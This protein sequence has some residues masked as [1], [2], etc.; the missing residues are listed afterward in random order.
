MSVLD[1]TSAETVKKLLKK[2][3]SHRGHVTRNFNSIRIGLGT[4]HPD[5][6]YLSDCLEAVKSQKKVIE[7]GFVSISDIYIENDIEKELDELTLDHEKY[8]TEIDTNM[9]NFYSMIFKH[10]LKMEEAEHLK[11]IPTKSSEIKSSISALKPVLPKLTISKFDGNPLK[12]TSFWDIF[13]SS[14]HDASYFA[15]I[16]KFCYLKSYL[17][18][19]AAETIEGVPTTEKGYDVA[20]E[21]LIKRFGDQAIT[22]DAY[23]VAI[24]NLPEPENSVKSLQKFS[25]K[26][27]TY[28]RLLEE[29]GKKRDDLATLLIPNI[30]NKLPNGVKKNVVRIAKNPKSWTLDEIFLGIDEEIEFLKVSAPVPEHNSYSEADC[31]TF[32]N[33]SNRPVRPPYQ[34]Q[35]NRAQPSYRP[36]YQGQQNRANPVVDAICVFCEKKHPFY[37]CDTHRD[38]RK[39]YEIIKSKHRCFVCFSDRHISVN[40]TARQQRCK[41]CSMRHNTLL[42]FSKNNTAVNFSNVESCVNMENSTVNHASDGND[43]TSNGQSDVIPV[44]NVP[45][46]PEFGAYHLSAVNGTVLLQTAQ[47]MVTNGQSATQANFLLD[48]GSQRSFISKKMCDILGLMPIKSET[49]KLSTFGSANTEVRNL[50]VVK[51]SII[52]LDGSKIEIFPLVIDTVCT[53]I[54]FRHQ[55]NLHT[56]HPNFVNLKFS[57]IINIGEFSVDILIGLDAYFSIVIGNIVQ[58]YTSG[59]VAIKTK[60]G[61]VVC[62]KVN[63]DSDDCEPVSNNFVHILKVLTDH[64]DL[65]ARLKTFWDLE[66]ISLEHPSSKSQKA[67]FDYNSYVNSIEYKDNKYICK[68]PVKSEHQDL[69]N[70]YLYCA[71]RLRSLIRNLLTRGMLDK[72][73]D[74]IKI[75]EKNGIIEKVNCDDK[76]GY[77]IP[78]FAVFRDSAT[79]PMRIVYDCSSTVSPEYPSLN[80]ILETGPPLQN[81][82]V[83]I[84]LKFRIGRYGLSSDISRAFH[85]LGLDSAHRGLCRFLWISDDENDK[86]SEFQIY[87]FLVILFGAKCSP[88]IL[89]ATVKK[90]LIL[91]TCEIADEILKCIY[92]DNPITTTDS[93]DHAIHFFHESRSIMSKGNFKLTAWASNCEEVNKLAESNSIAD[94]NLESVKVLGLRWNTHSDNLC[95]NPINF[96]IP[97]NVVTKRIALQW[98]SKLY[99]PL[100]VMAAVLMTGKLFMQEMWKLKFSWDIPFTDDL[101]N[102]WIDVMLNL[103]KASNFK[104]KRCILTDCTDKPLKLFAFCDASK[105][106]YACSLYLSDGITCEFIFS[107]GRVAPLKTVDKPELSLPRLELMAAYMLVRVVKFIKKSLSHLNLTEYYFSDSQVVLN[108]IHYVDRNKVFEFNRV[109]DI[110]EL[111]TKDQWYYVDSDNNPSDIVTRGC[112]YDKLI[113]KDN[114]FNGPAFLLKGPEY[115]PVWER[116]PPS[117]TV[118]TVNI[119]PQI[120]ENLSI[121]NLIDIE[122]FSS[123]SKLL[124]VTAYVLRAFKIN[125]NKGP[126]TVDE[127]NNCKYLWIKA[128][129]SKYFEAEFKA[130]KKDTS[131]QLVRQLNLYIDDN[132]LKSGGRIDNSDMAET[133]KYPILLPYDSYFSKLV[134]LH[135]HKMVHHSGVNSTINRVRLEFWVPKLRQL[136]KKLLHV[137]VVCKRVTGIHYPYPKCPPLVKCRIADALPWAVTGVDLTGSVTIMSHNLV[138]VTK[139][140]I[141]LF[142]CSTT[143]N[144]HLELIPDMTVNS[145]LLAFRRFCSRRSLPNMLIS[146]NAKYFENSSV[147]LQNLF[148]SDNLV[149]EL[150]KYSVEWFFIPKR[151]PWHGAFYERMIGLTKVLLRKI[152]GKSR[153]TYIE[154]STLLTEIECTLNERPITYVSS[155]RGDP[156]PLT[157]S[158]LLYGRNLNRI[159]YP[160]VDLDE[161]YDKDFDSR[162]FLLERAKRRAYLCNHFVHRWKY[163]YLVALRERHNCKGSKLNYVKIGDVV[164]I[165]D[166]V[167][168]LDWNMGIITELKFGKDGLV[169]SVNLRTKNGVTNRPVTKL[170]PI[171]VSDKN[172]SEPSDSDQ[173]VVDNSEIVINERPS[174]V[175]KTI[176]KEKIKTLADQ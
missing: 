43:A 115:W 144:I 45:D 28:I 139:A 5:I 142:T 3:S 8:L 157:P 121:D 76:S 175:A 153:L 138:N 118:V 119:E 172:M 29:D 95:L 35:Q 113:K 136:V 125:R 80:D 167:P 135:E 9:S 67:E 81:D 6:K 130:L 16:Q 13:K 94:S 155:D 162:S 128:I 160:A 152:L 92:V 26:L 20:I 85:A 58:S 34:G 88:F 38:P 73:K 149:S 54:R 63:I 1:A 57:H 146:D 56:L 123:L 10:K 21:L 166:D 127:L 126:I 23:S 40:C 98:I 161:I 66:S 18:A 89:N 44:D 147:Q 114:W 112:T 163:E 24:Q 33:Q 116:N 165:H 59:P 151:A 64:S 30:R 154:L 14:V 150:A 137:C 156:S 86:N 36:P 117:N 141:C 19:D 25:N 148:K 106:S 2:R 32:L 65:D 124:R 100:G 122:R 171:E 77:F 111:T 174:R 52:A 170:Y 83:S 7:D 4:E 51:L 48:S 55:I 72:Y 169:R 27:L 99:D 17:I 75:Q 102:L 103:D 53:P 140:Y 49:L 68:L 120:N 90:H 47:A 133:V 105:L 164:L 87:Q 84:L 39:R 70:N 42:C 134:V 145:F 107:R 31:A 46:L 158:L 78:H 104:F 69:P 110:N 37:Q 41:Y 131:T 93:L 97:S 79:T 143:R 74:L 159:P 176:A 71:N 173:P 11:S 101:F 109:K 60:L 91:N 108:W 62:G 50:D 129:Q 96:I 61:Y 15:K 132:I 22:T 168:R 12:W 82:M